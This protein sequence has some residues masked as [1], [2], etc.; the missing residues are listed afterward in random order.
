[1]G[2]DLRNAGL[3]VHVFDNHLLVQ[4]TDS[5]ASYLSFGGITNTYRYRFGRMF[6]ENDWEMSG[7]CT[8]QF[9]TAAYLSLG[10]AF[11]REQYIEYTQALGAL[12]DGSVLNFYDGFTPFP[13]RGERNSTYF[14]LGFGSFFGFNSLFSLKKYAV[15]FGLRCNMVQ[16]NG[17][18]LLH[19][20]TKTDAFDAFPSLLRKKEVEGGFSYGFVL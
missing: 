12:F 19:S 16:M 15:F 3:N 18:F 14:D 9:Y 2:F 4:T 8:I 7:N 5:S 6:F 17:Q 1:M 10:A 20:K 13:I 11:K